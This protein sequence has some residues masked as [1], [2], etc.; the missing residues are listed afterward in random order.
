VLASVMV[1]M[2]YSRSLADAFTFLT[3]M[4]TAASLPLYLFGGLA[5]FKLWRRGVV[6]HAAAGVVAGAAGT[7]VFSVW[8]FYG[9][10][11]ESFLWAIALG[12]LSLPLFWYARYRAKARL[13]TT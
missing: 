5:L 2:S 7:C 8:G 1:G 9:V 11:Q 12:A 6:R 10:G 3:V 13:V 4:V